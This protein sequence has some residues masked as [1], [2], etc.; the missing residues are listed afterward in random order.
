MWAT[1]SA[2]ARSLC[3]ES[4]GPTALCNICVSPYTNASGLPRRGRVPPATSPQAPQDGAVRGS[5][6][7]ERRDRGLGGLRWDRHGSFS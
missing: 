5:Q 3:R 4:G 7:G 6:H 1:E 2:A